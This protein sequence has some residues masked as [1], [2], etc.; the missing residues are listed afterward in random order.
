MVIDELPTAGAERRA[1]NCQDIRRTDGIV[2]LHALDGLGDDIVH[3]SAPAA[4]N[5][6]ND[7]SNRIV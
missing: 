2:L 6:G 4:V 5:G 1:D 3:R 7:V